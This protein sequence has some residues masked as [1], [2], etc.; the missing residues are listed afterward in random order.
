MSQFMALYQTLSS[1]Y[2]DRE[3]HLYS[4]AYLYSAACLYMLAAGGPGQDSELWQSKHIVTNCYMH[5][6]KS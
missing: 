5:T 3:A 1:L 2:W 4:T 6:K